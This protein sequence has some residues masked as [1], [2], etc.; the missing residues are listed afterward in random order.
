MKKW[1]NV[2]ILKKRPFSTYAFL[3]FQYFNISALNTFTLLQ[4][5]CKR[6]QVASCYLYCLIFPSFWVEYLLLLN[7]WLKCTLCSAK[8]LTTIVP[9]SGSLAGFGTF[10]CHFPKILR[11]EAS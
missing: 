10:S 5:L 11:T 4:S 1:S 3:G 2:E 8:R 9:C 7:I 6:A